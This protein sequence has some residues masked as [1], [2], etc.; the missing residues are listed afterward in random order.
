MSTRLINKGPNHI[1]PFSSNDL[2]DVFLGLYNSSY[3][4]NHV[5]F[6]SCYVA[7]YWHRNYRQS[8][9]NMLI[10]LYIKFMEKIFSHVRMRLKQNILVLQYLSTVHDTLFTVLD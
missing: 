2:H 10:F 7:H 6:E 3:I 1:G 8:M 5:Y 9:L 4:M